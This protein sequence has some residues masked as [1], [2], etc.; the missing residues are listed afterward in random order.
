MR[1][2]FDRSDPHRTVI[3]MDSD[4][5]KQSRVY[6]MDPRASWWILGI[7][8]TVVV[9]MAAVA[10]TATPLRVLFGYPSSSD[11]SMAMVNAVRIQAI[12]DSL[13]VQEEYLQQL[14]VLITDGAVVDQNPSRSLTSGNEVQG[15]EQLGQSS[16]SG[17]W[18]DHQQP[19]IPQEYMPVA[20]SPADSPMTGALQYVASLS[21]PALSPVNGI[22]TRA[23]NARAGHYGLDIATT[24][25]ST[26]R[27]IGNGYVIMADWTH[28]GG[29]SIAIQ[30]AGG[31]VS[32][33][34]HNSRLL[35]RVADRVLQRE[36]IA[37]SGDSGEH[38]SG[39][40]LH[41]ELWHN[42]LAQDPD[43]YLLDL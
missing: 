19:A 13:A 11:R 30:H 2:I 24:A 42:G 5:S 23:F 27:T 43:S 36:A 18:I 9:A 7:Y 34:K 3:V 1:E 20:T 37:L 14:R 6:T 12:D 26:V 21:L 10:L 35:K 33:Y 16:G 4:L 8:T 25:G 38:S 39:P 40:H 17:N 22:V 31:Y 29:Y 28:N 32:V 41:F 15:P